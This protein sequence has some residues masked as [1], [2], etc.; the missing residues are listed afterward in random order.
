MFA[1]PLEP[2][3]TYAR[4]DY[5]ALEEQA[6]IK[7][8]YHNGHIIAMAGASLKHNRIVSNVHASLY[9]DL[10]DSDCE[11]FMSD[12]RLWLETADRYTYP[13]LMV[14]CGE[15]DLA[16]GRTDTIT[17]PT[18]I[19]EIL[20]DSTANYDR[21]DKF[22]AYRSLNSF[23]EYLLID[24]HQPRVEYFRRK[25]DTSWE[26]G[27]FTQLAET[28]ALKSIGVELSLEQIYRKVGF[29]EVNKP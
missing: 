21:R 3:E 5:L 17:N 28:V 7:S 22:Q 23:V 12:L 24:Q 6:E 13:D 18:V 2:L 26:I 15:V 25:R 27:V 8:E 11:V 14:V 1:R 16:E 19:I 10:L 9:S 4:Q 20:S 29:E